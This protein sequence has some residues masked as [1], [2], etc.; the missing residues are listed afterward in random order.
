[1]FPMTAR[2]GQRRADASVEIS[3]LV[4]TCRKLPRDGGERPQVVVTM[5]LDKLQTQVAA[6]T[7]DDG[8]QLSPAALRRLACDAH[9]IPAILDGKG[10]VLDVGRERRLFTGSLRRTLV[11][12]DQGCAFPGCDRPPRRCEAHHATHWV[13]WVVTAPHNWLLR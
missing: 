13:H 10:Q 2:L 5:D 9:V 11:L 3:R 8:G 12:R 7:L 1:M 4:L 6:A